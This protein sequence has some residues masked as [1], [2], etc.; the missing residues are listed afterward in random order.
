MATTYTRTQDGR[1]VIT[2]TE[3]GIST[4][5]D[6]VKDAA[7]ELDRRILAGVIDLT[8]AFQ[9]V[10]ERMDEMKGTVDRLLAS[11][12]RPCPEIEVWPS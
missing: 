12:E 9:L 8:N 1:A 11:Y 6:N 7:D 5:Y 2:D 10:Q 4:I 3:T